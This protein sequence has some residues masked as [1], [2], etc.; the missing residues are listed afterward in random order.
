MNQFLAKALGGLNQ[1][2]AIG[3]GFDRPDHRP[4]LG[5]WL[6][7]PDQPH[8]RRDRWLAAGHHGLWPC[9][10]ARRHA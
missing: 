1:V 3:T 10:V 9:R 6:T 8:V 7:Y 5:E 4:D 2:L